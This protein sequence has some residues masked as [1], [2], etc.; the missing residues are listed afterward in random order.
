MRG[1]RLQA[2]GRG[3]CAEA[4]RPAVVSNGYEV[5]LDPRAEGLQTARPDLLRATS[6]RWPVSEAVPE[7]VADLLRVSREL[8]VH[9]PFSYDFFTVSVAWSLL[10][11]EAALRHRLQATVRGGLKDLIDRAERDGLVSSDDAERLHAGRQIRNRLSHPR[12]QVAVT[13]GL[14][15]VFLETTHRA[16]VRL[17]AGSSDGI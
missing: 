16:A 8:F 6:E 15:E 9:A 7:S 1:G 5:Q 4:T 3:N 11:L 10:A 14:A 13:P 17:Y 12:A 2:R